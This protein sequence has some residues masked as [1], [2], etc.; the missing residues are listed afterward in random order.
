MSAKLNSPAYNSDCFERFGELINKADSYALLPYETEVLF[1]DPSI[2]HSVWEQAGKMRGNGELIKLGTR[3]KCPVV[4]IH[5][6]YDPHPAEGVSIPLSRAL[7]DFRFIL[8]ER[9]GHRPWLELHARDDFYRILRTE[10]GNRDR[11]RGRW[12]A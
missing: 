2:Y 12:S 5:G 1:N 4:A 8:L 6:D 3:I 10:I 9:C 11:K 7:E